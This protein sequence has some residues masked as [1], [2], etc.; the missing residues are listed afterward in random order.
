MFDVT[1]FLQQDDPWFREPGFQMAEVLRCYDEKYRLALLLDP[2][3]ILEIGVRA[4]YSAAAFL[5]AAPLAHYVGID[6]DTCWPGAYVRAQTLLEGWT[7]SRHVRILKGDTQALERLPEGHFDMIH[8]DGDHS[9][10]GTLHDLK[11]AYAARPKWIVLDDYDNGPIVK[12]AA[13]EFLREHP[14]P[15]IHLPTFRG[16]LVIQRAA[17]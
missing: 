3:S 1:P 11:L 14:L 7:P 12:A 10:K 15:H 16:D 8:V 5:T 17:G 2:G 4:G 6:N 9:F 13:Q